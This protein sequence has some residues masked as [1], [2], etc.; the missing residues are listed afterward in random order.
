MRKVA[1]T[2]ISVRAIKAPERGQLTV[3]DTHSP[4]GVRVSQ[5]GS[6]TFIVMLGSGKRHVIGRFGII[7]LAEARTEA[8]RILAEKTLGIRKIVS[9][10]TF[11]SA[12]STF[13]EDHYRDKKPRTE[14]EAKRLLERHFLP[15]FRAKAL[16]DIGDLEIGRCLDKIKGTP[17]EQLHA[18]RAIR[19]MLRWSTRPPRRYIAHSPLEGYQAP[20]Q[21]RKGT[22]IL[23]DKELAA[24]W[25]AANGQFGDMVKLLILWGTRNGET[26]RLRRS[27]LEKSVLTIPGAYTKNKRDHAIPILPI[28]RSIL[29]EQPKGSDYFFPGKSPG[30]HFNDGSWGKFKQGLDKTSGVYGWQLRDLRRTFRSNMPKIGVSRELSERL[31]NHVTGV[32]T[33]LDEIYD[34]YEYVE[35]KRA[36]LRKWEARLHQIIGLKLAPKAANISLVG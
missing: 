4:L 31:V 17:S 13:L 35:E 3:W 19:T 11:A 18:F 30:T 6:K 1:L 25:H 15:A 33:E 20:S 26:G 36:A 10:I 7:M 5:G 12:L 21:D 32:K 8:R 34:R 2:E 16:A 22:R 29:E 23:S 28:A 14:H 27:W 9:T 24:V